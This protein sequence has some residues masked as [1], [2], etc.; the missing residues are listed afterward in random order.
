MPQHIGVAE[1]ETLWSRAAYEWP[2]F[3][4]KC[5]KSQFPGLVTRQR[6]KV[7]FEGN[8][9]ARPG[10]YCRR[11]VVH[12]AGKSVNRDAARSSNQDYR[13]VLTARSPSVGSMRMSM[14]IIG[15]SSG[16]E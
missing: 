1:G 16:A 14:S 10:S 15:R 13:T 8:L 11:K 9:K 3:C 2:G 12:T 7:Y 5:L 6:I 4:R